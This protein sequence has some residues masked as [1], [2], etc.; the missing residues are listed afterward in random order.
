MWC[1]MMGFSKS[2][3]LAN[4]EVASFSRCRNI[5]ETQNF[6]ELP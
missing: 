3:P 6:G 4:F 1:F 2:Q 5:E